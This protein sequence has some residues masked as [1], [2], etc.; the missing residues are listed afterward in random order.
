M[1]LATRFVTAVPPDVPRWLASRDQLSLGLGYALPRSRPCGF[2]AEW[3]KSNHSVQ[4]ALR[5][6][7]ADGRS[8]NP[9]LAATARQAIAAHQAA[10]P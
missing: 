4:L 2:A 8:P 5:R 7:Q 9:F 10:Q 1:W 6:T 3:G